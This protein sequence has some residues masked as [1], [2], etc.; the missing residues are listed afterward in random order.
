MKLFERI[1][2]R[3]YP[4]TIQPG[5]APYIPGL[6]LFITALAVSLLAY[7]DYGITWDEP[8]M[9]GLGLAT[10]DYISN[11]SREMFTLKTAHYG[12]LFELLLVC[13]EKWA[14]LTDS[15]DIYLMRHLVTNLFFLLSGFSVYVLAY[16]QFKNKLVA[17]LGFIM[18]VFAPRIYAHSFFNTRD[19]PFLSMFMITLC[20]CQVAFEKNRKIPFFILGMLCACTTGIRIMGILLVCFTLLFLVIDII[21]G[22][23]NKK[24]TTGNVWNAL[25]FS[26][27]FCTTLYAVWPYLWHAPLQGFIDSFNSFT[28]FPWHGSVLLNGKMELG[29]NLP[30]TYFPIWFLISSPELWLIAGLAGILWIVARFIK[31]PL[32]FLNNTPDRNLLLYLLCFS[33]PVVAVIFLHS[34]IYNDWRHLY[35]VY[36][37]FIMMALYVIDKMLR[38]R[39]RYAIVWLCAMQVA[40]TGSFMIRN[41][42]FSQVYFN[43][44]VPHTDEY[45][46]HHYELD[47]WASSFKIGLE[48]IIQSNPPGM[49]KVSG[50]YANLVGNNIMLLS[51]DKRNRI[52][53]VNMWDADYVFIN[54]RGLPNGQYTDEYIVKVLNSTVLGVYK[55]NRSP[56]K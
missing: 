5:F 11:G 46:G 1:Q 9:R 22:F 19:V 28:R 4:D 13:I 31:K 12:S 21:S 53:L 39:F 40:I 41:H 3:P 24:S 10:Y 36:P 44:F 20:Y 55:M 50:E 48:H 27:G 43:N 37:P 33:V 51:R 52:Q 34:V 47:Y 29:T 15:S 32:N 16:R 6:L 8:E 23:R 7:Q 2:V 56:Q 49:I 54:N 17:G 14:H 30:W 42:P 35:F 38:T 25:L 18:F 45:L 26:A